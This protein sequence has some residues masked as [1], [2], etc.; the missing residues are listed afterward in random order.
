MLT[1]ALIGLAACGVTPQ[2]AALT[3]QVT[4]QQT[5][6][7]SGDVALDIVDERSGTMVG[8]R[9][10][11]GAEIRLT[12]VTSAIEPH[13]RDALLANKFRPVAKTAASDR[14][15]KIEVRAVEL[16]FASGFWTGGYFPRA[17]LKA[18]ATNKGQTFERF[19]RSE[20]E[21]R[22]AVVNP[23][24]RNN[25][26]LSEVVSKAVSDLVNDPELMGFLAR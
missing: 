6:A 14:R 3:T 2:T 1:L 18:V 13:V 9:V 5:A 8:N 21:S 23:E 11:G 20:I 25:Q 16:K 24:D 12:D 4:T 19:Y 22:S 10:A 7:G 26:L 15:L 17:A